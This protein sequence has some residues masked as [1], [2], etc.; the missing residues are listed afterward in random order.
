V[1]LS[2]N[3][4]VYIREASEGRVQKSLPIW[5]RATCPD[6]RS[7]LVLPLSA[8]GATIGFIYADYGQSNVRR[9]T[10]EEVALLKTLKTQVALALRHA[11]LLARATPA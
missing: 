11:N 5:H 10:T 4:D 8:N 1:A 2:R 6:A 7:F 9:L 3:A